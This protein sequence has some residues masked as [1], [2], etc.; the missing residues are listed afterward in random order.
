MYR[1]GYIQITSYSLIILVITFGR[2]KDCKPIVKILFFPDSILFC[3]KACICI[4]S[5]R[6]LNWL[7]ISENTK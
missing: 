6:R 2:F 5:R 7:T 3:N 1:Y 4:T